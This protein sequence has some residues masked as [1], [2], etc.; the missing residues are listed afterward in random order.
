MKKT[1]ILISIT[2]SIFLYSVTANAQLSKKELKN[3]P[4]FIKNHCELLVKEAASDTNV[5]ISDIT[6]NLFYKEFLDT[7]KE[8]NPI[9]Y[10]NNLPALS[11]W[12]DE[13][14]EENYFFHPAYQKLPVLAVSKENA[15][16]YCNWLQETLKAEYPNV[17]YNVRLAHKSEL[18]F[19][20]LSTS[21]ATIKNHRS[22]NETDTLFKE[23]T[24]QE[25]KGPSTSLSFRVIVEVTT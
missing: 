16:N 6:S 4:T 5:Y 22:K 1:I 25:F 18:Q 13:I 14:L 24:N 21:T 15:L 2:L 8:S 10:K 19:A 3:L 20:M 9:F 7:Y 23:G 12:K 17:T 11:I